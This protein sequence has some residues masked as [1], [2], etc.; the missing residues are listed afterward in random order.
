MGKRYGRNQKRRARE[1]IQRLEKQQDAAKQCIR[2]MQA[3]LKRNESPRQDA[4]QEFVR[5]YDLIK[6]A[7]DV[8]AQEIGKQVGRE[9]APAA[10]KLY[11]EVMSM[12]DAHITFDLQQDFSGKAIEVVRGEL[13]AN[14][15][16][17]LDTMR[18]R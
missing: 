11:R 17:T 4:F 1:E 15:N 13:R 5:R 7:V 16:I 10:A 2:L 12:P 3:E 14:Y 9:L 8:I 6:Y 18:I